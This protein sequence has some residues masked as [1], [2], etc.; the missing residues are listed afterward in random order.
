LATK[1]LRMDS[2]A[3]CRDTSRT[4]IRRWLLL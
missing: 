3:T 2:S 1:S 4:S